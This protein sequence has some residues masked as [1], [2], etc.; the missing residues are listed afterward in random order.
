MLL[1]PRAH[2]AGHLPVDNNNCLWYKLTMTNTTR[3]SGA[4]TLRDELGQTKPFES[5]AT[6]AYLNLV[7]THGY[8]AQAP[9]RLFRDHK[10]TATTYNI[11]RILRGAGPEG[12]RCSDVTARLV[13][14]VPDLTRLV[15][16]LAKMGLVSRE[17]PESDR[18]SVL[19]KL[20]EQGL[21]TLAELD[22]PTAEIHER[23]LNHMTREELAQ[24]SAL[25]VKAR[26]PFVT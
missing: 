9:D 16:R 18:R 11:L 4:G 2:S 1:H 8:L 17:V 6:E 5:A 14:R 21:A 26:A 3:D 23:Q 25:L 10:L 7:R 20:T 15:D 24:L 12:L 22:R 19:L 13:T